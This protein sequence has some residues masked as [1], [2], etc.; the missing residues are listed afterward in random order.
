MHY[1]WPARGRGGGRNRDERTRAQVIRN[2]CRDRARDERVGL[3]QREG[4]ERRGKEKVRGEIGKQRVRE[5]GGR[6][7]LLRI[8]DPRPSGPWPLRNQWPYKQG[9]L[10]VSPVERY[11][12]VRDVKQTYWLATPTLQLRG[13]I[14]FHWVTMIV[15]VHENTGLW[16][17]KSRKRKCPWRILSYRSPCVSTNLGIS[18]SIWLATNRLVSYFELELFDF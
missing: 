6:T 15:K 18:R 7:H 16:H 14:L 10:S 4:T 1:A 5:R 9:T 17:R 13:S 11:L 12:C 8:A 3:E 2:R